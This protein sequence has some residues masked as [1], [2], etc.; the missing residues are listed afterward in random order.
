MRSAANENFP[1]TFHSIGAAAARV[2]SSISD[3]KQNKNEDRTRD[4][5]RS[6]D[7]ERK[8]KENSDYIKQR[9][10]ELAAFERRANGGR[11]P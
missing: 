8:P 10:R 4:A 7:D 11:K 2:V 9:L 3:D 5:D 1:L 6:E